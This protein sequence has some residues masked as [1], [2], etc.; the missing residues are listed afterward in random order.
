[1]RMYVNRYTSGRK[2]IREMVIHSRCELNFTEHIWEDS[3]HSW[4]GNFRIT[5]MKD[6]VVCQSMFHT[7]DTYTDYEFKLGWGKLELSP[8]YAQPKWI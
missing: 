4:N 6:A 2:K 8:Y 5:K 1:M 3:L 7:M